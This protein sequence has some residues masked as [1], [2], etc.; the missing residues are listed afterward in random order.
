MAARLR[1]LPRMLA[2]AASGRYPGMGRGRLGLFV[3]A[4]VY[5][6]SPVDVVPELF[7]TVLGL[8]DDAVVALWLSGAFLVETSRFLDWERERPFI[9]EQPPE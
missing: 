5:I 1:A 2:G 3:L 9:V 7:L 4:L 6:V 8:G